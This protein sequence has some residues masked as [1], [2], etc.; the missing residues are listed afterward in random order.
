MREEVWLSPS[1]LSLSSCDILTDYFSTSLVLLLKNADPGPPVALAATQGPGI[2]CSAGLSTLFGRSRAQR[3]VWVDG[4]GLGT[5]SRALSL[6]SGG[7]VRSFCLP[8]SDKA[9]VFRA[10]SARAAPGGGAE[11]LPVCI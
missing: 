9:A 8:L 10:R 11:P 7:R 4:P 5:Q 3:V 2:Q 1:P 6:C